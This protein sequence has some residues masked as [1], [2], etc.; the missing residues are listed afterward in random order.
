MLEHFRQIHSLLRIDNKAFFDEVLGVRAS[1]DVVRELESPSFDL[2][3]SLL[4]F[5]RLKRRSPMEHSVEDHA[6]GPEI[7]L[8]AVTVPCVEHL[9]S[10]IVWCTTYCALTL[11]IVKNL[12]SK[13]KIADFKTHAICEE[14][15]AEF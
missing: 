12:S 5:L 6:D 8:I 13:S 15:V 14:K 2:L 7:H 11:A 4:D 3:V 1:L 9:W 10:Q